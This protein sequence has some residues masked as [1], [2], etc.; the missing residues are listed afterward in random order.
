[1]TAACFQPPCE[2]LALAAESLPLGVLLLQSPQDEVDIEQ[3]LGLEIDHDHDHDHEQDEDD[4]DDRGEAAGAFTVPALHAMKPEHDNSC[5]TSRVGDSHL[6]L[7][8]G[9]ATASSTQAP[10]LLLLLLPK[11]RRA[12]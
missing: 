6:Q 3:E 9:I 8:C 1:M 10:C 7:F 5:C 4:V 11:L 12:N 2:P